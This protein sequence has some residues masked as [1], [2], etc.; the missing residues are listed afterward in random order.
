MP[1]SS[2]YQESDCAVVD[3]V[4]QIAKQRGVPNAQIALAWLLH[5]PGVAAPIIGASKPQH[6]DDAIAALGLKLQANEIQS[7][8]EPYRPH[9]ILGHS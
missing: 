8:E 2:Y 5:K 9:A 3:R 1:T 7:L 6:I 4:T